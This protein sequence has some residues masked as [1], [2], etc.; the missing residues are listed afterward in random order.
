M[1]VIQAY[2]ERALRMQG[3]LGP[4]QSEPVIGILTIALSKAGKGT[5]I[6]WEYNVGG[7][8]RYEVP[9]IAKAVDAVMGQQ[10]AALGKLLGPAAMPT[11]KPAT[12]G[13]SAIEADDDGANGATAP[14]VPVPKVEP[15][16]KVTPAPGASSAPKPTA[17]PVIKPSTT[18]PPPSTSTSTPP[19]TPVAKPVV[20]A[21]ARP[22]PKPAAKPATVPA[23]VG[24][25]FADLERDPQA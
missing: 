23:T 2:P 4:L 12:K 21:P 17:A 5:R 25:A 19:S 16:L 18:P 20:P 14:G 24:D 1:R 13:E 3:A 7:S 8:M 11:G 6:V 22:I 15:L 10:M 9:V